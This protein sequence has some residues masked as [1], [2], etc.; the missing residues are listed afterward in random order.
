MSSILIDW[1]YKHFNKCNNEQFR[2]LLGGIIN[3]T[4]VM[5]PTMDSKV[6]EN[7]TSDLEPVANNDYAVSLQDQ[8]QR[9]LVRDDTVASCVAAGDQVRDYKHKYAKH[10][11]GPRKREKSTRLI[12]NR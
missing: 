1:G 2:K 8:T 3:R 5:Y 6:K 4:D 7:T 10:G 9:R 11:P 12:K